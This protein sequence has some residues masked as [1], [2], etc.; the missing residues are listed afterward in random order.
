MFPAN[1]SGNVP[2]TRTTG[3]GD[4]LFDAGVDRAGNAYSPNILFQ[5]DPSSTPF[6]W[7]NGPSDPTP[8]R[9]MTGAGLT[10]PTVI[11]V[12][13][14]VSGGGNVSAPPIAQIAQGARSSGAL[15]PHVPP[16]P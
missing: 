12:A 15:A 14:D 6:V 10:F 13:D 4:L 11:L 7:V 16:C 1:P 3:E 2:P 8:S 9:T 5:E